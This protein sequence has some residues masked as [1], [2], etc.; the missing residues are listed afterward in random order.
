MQK[1]SRTNVT[2]GFI[3]A[4]TT[5]SQAYSKYAYKH[6]TQLVNL[7]LTQ[8]FEHK[9]CFRN[10][11]IPVVKQK[12]SVDINRN[13]LCSSWGS[14]L[15]WISHFAYNLMV[16]REYEVLCAFGCLS[17]YAVV[18]LNWAAKSPVTDL[19]HASL[20]P[21]AHTVPVSPATWQGLESSKTYSF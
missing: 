3:A 1:G 13:S 6:L 9:L 18:I 12:A 2:D 8:A 19:W 17:F 20:S 4:V 16:H 14:Y 21:V 7:N 11:G 5:D 15:Y 10:T